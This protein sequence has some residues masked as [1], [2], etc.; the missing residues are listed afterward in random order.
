MR[1]AARIAVLEAENTQLWEALAAAQ[2][3]VAALMERVAELERGRGTHSQ[4]SS[5]PPSQD[6]GRPRPRSLRGTSGKRPG[7]QPEHAGASLRLSAVPDWVESQRPAVC[8][9]CA[10]SLADLPVAGVERRQVQDLPPV[11][12]EVTEHQGLRVRCP[13]CRTLTT[14]AFP[15][16]VS[17]PV[18]YGPR[19]RAAA[20]CLTQ[21][22][23]LPYNRA[24][25]VLGDLL[26]TALSTGTV[27]AW[28]QE[29]AAGLADVEAEIV[30]A[31]RTG[32]LLHNDET[33]LCV[34]GT[35]WWLHTASTE[36]LTHYGV[37]PKRGRE[38]ME[39]LGI[40]PAFRGTSMHDGWVPYRGYA[41]RHVLCNAHHLR[42]LAGIAEEEGQ[43]WATRM[44]AWLRAAYQQ[45]K[46]ARAVGQTALPARTRGHP[47]ALRPTPGPGTSGQ[48]A[49][50]GV[51]APQRTAPPHQSPELAGPLRGHRCRAGLCG[52]PRYPFR[53]QP[54]RAR[55]AHG[56]GAAESV[57]H[58]P[59]R[60]RGGG[61]RPH[62]RLLLHPPQAGRLRVRR[63]HLPLSG[64]ASPPCPR[65]T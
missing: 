18:Q 39:A 8:A 59:Q 1:E 7:G 61:F 48:P 35:G 34:Q 25:A 31:L 28:V 24:Q 43:E 53:Q 30:E 36:Q 17:A 52:R 46:R 38:A 12:L 27:A 57:R 16:G 58:V 45:V 10:A 64:P 54:S 9:G 44:A 23:L 26:G 56:Q 15:A 20:V 41:C 62:P 49:A 50:R 6:R 11:R 3:A 5:Q 2:E 37:H 19:V 47:P 42:E 14:G 13:R 55:R 65:L 32:T 51:P 21:Q 63:L 60:G 40:L 29:A 4:N 22:H 33:G